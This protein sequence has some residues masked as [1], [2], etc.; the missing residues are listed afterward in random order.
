MR[1]SETI[2]KLAEALAKARSEFKPVI[3]DSENPYFK[4][5]YADLSTVIEA[6]KD[7]LSKHGLVIIQSPGR[8]ID[9]R[10]V[11]VI[12]TLLAHSSGE[13]IEDDLEMMVTKVDAQG[14]GSGCT[15]G[16]RYSYQAFVNV[17]GEV[18]DDAESATGRTQKDRKGSSTDMSTTDGENINPTQ[19]RA[20]WS[21]AKQGNKSKAD[22][23]KW[24]GEELGIEHTDEMLKKDFNKA[25]KWAVKP[26]DDLTGVLQESIKERE[27]VKEPF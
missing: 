12:T 15:Y 18:D 25:M 7:G 19:V 22:V 14:I 3:K 8:F 23:L 5:S 6:T 4:S 21:A 11:I 20:F 9:E 16:R 24:F 13:W 2:G 27:L 1:R 17:S 10:K 26:S